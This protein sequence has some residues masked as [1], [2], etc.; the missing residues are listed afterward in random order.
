MGSVIQRG[1][2]VCLGLAEVAELGKRLLQSSDEGWMILFP[3]LGEIDDAF[4]SQRLALF[5]EGMDDFPGEEFSALSLA[6]VSS[7]V[8]GMDLGADFQLPRGLRDAELLICPG[9]VL[10][11]PIR[12]E[13]GGCPLAFA[14]LEKIR[15]GQVSEVVN[16]SIHFGEAEGNGFGPGAVGE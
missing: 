9:V 2:A 7:P 14:G 1:G 10:A 3:Y 6:T 16:G 8:F 11:F 13:G 15:C 4:P 12:L 5:G